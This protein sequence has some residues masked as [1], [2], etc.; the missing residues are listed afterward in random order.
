MDAQPI[1]DDKGWLLLGYDQELGR[2]LWGALD[3]DNEI[4]IR[5]DYDVTPI[6][7]ANDADRNAPENM[8]RRFGEWERVASVPIGQLHK[9]LD[10]AL[11][12][13]D[14]KYIRR[15][16]NDPDHRKFRTFRSRS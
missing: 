3:D 10:P 15:Y 6:L 11:D 2:T 8:S 5:A 7:E 14:D 12:Q 1:Y 9:D 4:V 13:N 16:L